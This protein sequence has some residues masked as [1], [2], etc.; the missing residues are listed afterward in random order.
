MIRF[1]GEAPEKVEKEDLLDYFL[2]VFEF[3]WT[4]D[5]YKDKKDHIK[6]FFTNTANQLFPQF[7]E[8][9][10]SKMWWSYALIAMREMTEYEGMVFGNKTVNYLIKKIPMYSNK[11]LTRQIN[12][13]QLAFYHQVPE[14]LLIRPLECPNL[15]CDFEMY[16]VHYP[17][18]L[19]NKKTLIKIFEKNLRQKD[20]DK[21]YLS[22]FSKESMKRLRQ[23]STFWNG[24]YELFVLYFVYLYHYQM[25]QAEYMDE[26]DFREEELVEEMV[27]LFLTSSISSQERVEKTALEITEFLKDNFLKKNKD[28]V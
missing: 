13:L 2:Y 25:M 1:L 14:H 3:S 21:H 12:E 11:L 26:K 15:D 10:V 22:R 27:I 23:F 19:Q 28:D 18:F 17:F 24:Y 4:M 5:V 6:D 20:V 9:P 7:H 8:F 16:N